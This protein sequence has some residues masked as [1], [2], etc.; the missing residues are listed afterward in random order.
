MPSRISG[1][2]STTVH[3]ILV[4]QKLFAYNAFITRFFLTETYMICVNDFYVLRNE[5]VIAK[6]GKFYKRSPYSRGNSMS[7]IG[8]NWN[9]VSENIKNVDAYHESYSLK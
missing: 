3:F 1:R 8:S 9:F 4:C 7:F 5:N 6:V 2:H